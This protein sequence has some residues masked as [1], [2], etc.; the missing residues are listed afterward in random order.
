MEESGSSSSI[1]VK[2]PCCGVGLILFSR[3]V[4]GPSLLMPLGPPPLFSSSLC[5][6]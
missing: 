1:A 3:P 2:G 4:L 5:F 6:I